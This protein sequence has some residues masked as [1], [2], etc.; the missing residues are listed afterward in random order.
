MSDSLTDAQ[1]LIA[2]VLGT[3]RL[4]QGMRIGRGERVEWWTCIGC[5]WESPLFSLGVV[6]EDVK[7]AHLAVEIDKA[8]GGLTREWGAQMLGD[9]EITIGSEET[10][11]YCAEQHPLTWT[12]LSRLVGGWTPTDTP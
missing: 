4:E 12:A 9:D 7:R 10:A 6:M 5:G 3:H 2:E 8:L 11:R 1:K